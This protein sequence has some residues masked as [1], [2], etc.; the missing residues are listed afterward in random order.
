MEK[1]HKAGVNL[2]YGS[3]LLGPLQAAQLYEFRLRAQ[4]QAPV[5]II[6]AATATAARLLK[7]D[8]VIGTL[9]AGSA[10]DVLVVDGNPLED[11]T[12][13]TAPERYLRYVI[14]AGAPIAVAESGA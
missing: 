14:R 5:D 9:A 1:A 4:V 11:I 6:R 8:G 7:L 12:V 13:L 10:G 2:V 3:D